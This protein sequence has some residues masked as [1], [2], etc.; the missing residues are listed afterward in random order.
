MTKGKVVVVAAYAGRNQRQTAR[1][2]WAVS[3][4][5]WKKDPNFA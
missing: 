3:Y 4:I 5:Q 1:L 2:V